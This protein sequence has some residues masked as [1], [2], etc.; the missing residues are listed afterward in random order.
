MNDRLAAGQT[1]ID[2]LVAAKGAR[3]I[4]NTLVPYDEAIRQLNAGTY[5]ANLM[6][7]VHPDATFRDLA[8]SLYKKGAPPS[9]PCH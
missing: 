1:S 8:Q 6:F 3:T 4:E 9:P 5:L 7:Q 2:Q